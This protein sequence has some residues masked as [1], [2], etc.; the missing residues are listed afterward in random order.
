MVR[1]TYTSKLVA[2]CPVNDDFDIYTVVIVA[3]KL[4]LAEDITAI[5]LEFKGK[6]AYQENLT[7]QLAMKF[8]SYVRLEG[9]HRGVFIVSEFDPSTKVEEDVG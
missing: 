2:K 6:E 7:E 4:I 5:L 8:G 1:N 3:T 9:D